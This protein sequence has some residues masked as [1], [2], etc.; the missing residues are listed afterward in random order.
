MTGVE[1]RSVLVLGGGGM[2][3]TAVCRELLAHKPARIAIAARRE[4]KAR[5]AVG[6]LSAAHP[7]LADRLAP[8]WGDV[9]LRAEWQGETGDARGEVMADSE[10]RRR[11]IADILDPLDDEILR[12]SL[13]F[14]MIMGLAPGLEGVRA[15]IVVDC[16]NTATAVSYQDIYGLARR[17]AGL[18][19]SDDADTN[20]PREVETLVAALSVPQL[21]RHVQVL[22]AAM[23]EAG[24]QAYVKIGTSGTGGMGFNIPYTHGEEKPSRLLLS[25]AALAGAQT[26]LTF[27]M[28]RTPDAPPLVREIKPTALIGWHEIAYGPIR[29]RGQELPL[30]DCPPDNAV[31]VEQKANVV[32]QGDFGISTGEKLEGVYVDTGENGLFTADEFAAITTL[33]QMQLITPEEVARTVVAELLGGNTGRDVIAALDGSVSGPTYRGG[34][35]RE[36]ALAR[37]RQ[38]EDQHGQAVAYEVLGPPRL[39]KLLYEAYLL[40]SVLRDV[41]TAIG[42]RPEDLSDAL[43][44]RVEQDTNLRRRILSIGIPILL[45]DG[46]RLLRGPVIKSENAHGGWVDLTPENMGKWQSRLTEIRREI[47][48]ELRGDTSS[49]SERLFAAGREWTPTPWL[50]EPGEA[51]GWIFLREES[52]FRQKS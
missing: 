33:G 14:E 4:V 20:W 23:R 28:A 49:Q 22:Y 52:G 47:Q 51:V 43:A 11:A 45:P 6:Q 30:F 19:E 35:L 13:L 8:V 3:G 17:L 50:I 26:M 31:S 39:S 21:V 2:V 15:E 1:G 42:M 27:L 16:M 9:F 44:S 5:Q 10:K 25:K 32:A 34:Y 24:T 48:A 37:L 41:S 7:E 12:T 38:L 29:S 18:A 40:K 36:A 46:V